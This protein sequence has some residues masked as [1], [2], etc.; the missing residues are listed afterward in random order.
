M[1]AF[2]DVKVGYVTQVVAWYLVC[3]NIK[4]YLC[5]RTE[6]KSE[7]EDEV[8][9]KFADEM[10][11]ALN[12][13]ERSCSTGRAAQGFGCVVGTNSYTEA[14]GSLIEAFRRF[15]AT[16]VQAIASK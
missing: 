7:T 15:N 3:Q 8:F 5:P 12:H 14:Q 6:L 1:L 11:M 13:M 4:S 9:A 2:E 10:D 16:R